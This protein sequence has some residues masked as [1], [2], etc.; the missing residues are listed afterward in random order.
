MST[1]ETLAPLVL[2]FAILGCSPSIDRVTRPHAI[3]S[4]GTG[5]G[6]NSGGGG[7]TIA[8]VGIT[9][10][11]EFDQRDAALVAALGGQKIAAGAIV[12]IRRDGDANPV[13]VQLDSAGRYEFRELLAGSYTISISRVLTA[14]ERA[15]AATVAADVD[16]FV[17][18]M[19]VDAFSGSRTVALPTSFGRRGSL[20][21]SEVYS[22]NPYDASTG[23]YYENGHYIELFN[24]SDS[25]IFLDKLT[26]G[27]GFAR[28]HDHA[29]F[30]CSLYEPLAADTLGLW[31]GF[32][33]RIPGTGREFPLAPGQSSLLASD[34]IDHSA[35]N[36]LAP[37]LRS[38]R[39]EFAGSNDP[40]NPAIPNIIQ[41]GPRSISRSGFRIFTLV[42]PIIVA[43][44]LELGDLVQRPQPGSE[45]VTL[46][47][48]PADAVIDVMV[49]KVIFDANVP[50]CVG[51][52]VAERFDRRPAPFAQLT[53]S[54]SL[55]RKVIYIRNGRAVLQRTGSS[56]ADFRESLRT[57]G[58]VP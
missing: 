27:L 32:F 42:A 7:G 28:S 40:D 15:A 24:N 43:R 9:V 39:F 18:D 17:G 6:G 8:R 47:R 58:T 5:G 1:R 53:G 22:G 26:I 3:D 13:E 55:H 44:N 20:V 48:I 37:D 10:L 52:P 16:A 11:V 21:V 23:T 29:N 54:T 2:A 19:R 36:R 45:Q 30:P 46:A 50:E 31:T 12:S 51:P 41:F 57:P 25:T 38:A 14:T 34:A 35:F 4:T 33:W 49:R 56:F